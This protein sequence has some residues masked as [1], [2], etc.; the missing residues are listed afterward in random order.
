[1]QV[2]AEVRSIRKEEHLRT[3]H[4]HHEVREVLE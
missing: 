2:R 4:V 3:S 1:M